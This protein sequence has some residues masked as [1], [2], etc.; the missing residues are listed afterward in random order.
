MD[1]D[2]NYGSAILESSQTDDSSENDVQ[3]L[4]SLNPQSEPNEEPAQNEE[5]E[6]FL[7]HEENK[8][9]L[10]HEDGQIYGSSNLETDQNGELL[11]F[12]DSFESDQNKEKIEFITKYETD[13]ELEQI[14]ELLENHSKAPVLFYRYSTVFLCHYIFIDRFII[15]FK[16]VSFSIR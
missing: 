9:K 14:R 1:D 11:P 6:H 8:K 4:V 7:S 5:N 15:S 10:S 13:Y 2:Q 16:N 3:N 12:E